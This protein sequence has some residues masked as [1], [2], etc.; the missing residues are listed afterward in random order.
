MELAR[1]QF[2]RSLRTGVDCYIIVF[3]LDDYKG[4]SDTHGQ[5]AAD[6]A[7]MEVATR[8]KN[9]IR[10]YD[11]LGRYTG[12]GFII[13]MTDIAVINKEHVEKAIERILRCI[14][15]TPIEYEGKSINVSAC[16]GVSNAAPVHEMSEAIKY[17]DEALQAAKINKQYPI[18]FHEKGV[19][20]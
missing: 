14:C 2:A 15:D 8:V 16:F 10:P 5:I 20:M 12:E 9:A 11:I 4:M 17:A 1:I 19:S 18:V 6:H 7:L 3:D 13:L